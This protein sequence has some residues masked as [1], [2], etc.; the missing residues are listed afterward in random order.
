MALVLAL[1][2]RD[3]EEAGEGDKDAEDKLTEAREV[4]WALGMP[5]EDA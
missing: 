4:L 5:D 2:V 1:V 3:E